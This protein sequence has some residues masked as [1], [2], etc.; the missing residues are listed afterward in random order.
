MLMPLTQK[1]SW[2][3]IQHRDSIHS[4]LRELI[5]TQQLPESRKTNGPHTKLKL[6]HN[7]YTEGKLFIDNDGMIMIRTPDGHFNGS[8][9]SVPPSIFPGLASAL[10][11]QFDHPSRGQLASLMDRYFYTPGGRAVIDNISENCLQCAA[12]RKLPKVLLENTTQTPHGM[13]SN[14][15]VDIIERANQKILEVKENLSSFVRAQ[16]VPDQT[17]NTLKKAIIKQVVDIIPESGA[18]IRADCAT[19]FQSLANKCSNPKSMLHK[20]GI[21]I[22]LGRTLNPNKNPTAEIC[23]Q[24]LQKEILKLTNKPGPISSLELSM[25]VRNMNNRIRYNGLTAKEIMFRRNLLDNEPI[26]VDDSELISTMKSNRK[27]S[28]QSSNSTKSKTHKTTPPQ[29]F[30]VGDLCQKKVEPF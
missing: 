6:L 16:F 14:F 30:N 12:M 10:H 24:E 2:K 13:A 27:L 17:A 29:N 4:K 3:N 21:K 7:K 9:I 1:P 25:A 8:V 19:S 28:S 15:A 20:L 23:N 22:I 18:E 5:V 11:A 26:P